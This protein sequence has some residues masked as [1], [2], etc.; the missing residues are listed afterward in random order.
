MECT[1]LP[2]AGYLPFRNRIYERSVKDRIP[3]VGSIEITSMCNLNC[4]HCYISG[5]YHPAAELTAAEI[6]GIVDQ[7][8]EEQCLW[9][10]LTGG[11]PL[12]RKDFKE[13]Y[14][15]VKRRGIIPMLFT[16]ATLVTDEIADLLASEPPYL[17]EISLYGAT[18]E[19]YERVTK[20]RG[21]FEKCMLG[22][23]KLLDRG[24]KIYLKTMV[25][26]LNSHE[27]EDMK[28]LARKLGVPFRFDTLINYR[29]DGS[30]RPANLRLSPEETVELDRQDPERMQNWKEL[31]LKFPAGGKADNLIYQCGAGISSFH[32]DSTGKL[33]V[34][35]MSR[36][37]TYDLRSGN[38][39]EGWTLFIPEVLAREWSR[40]VPCRE[41]SLKSMC[42]QC[43]GWGYM[44]NG[45]PEEKV[46]YLCA[47][48]NARAEM[49]GFS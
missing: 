5:S 14:R 49:L 42:G 1:G 43:P 45:D 18:A 33:S 21:S 9:L 6:K 7:L 32:I 24:I 22:I 47:V 34:C 17:V 13:I 31:A 44:E 16:N 3:L 2:D 11:E 8:A 23:S 20:V 15:Y 25:M 12:A 30:S 38:F 37:E 10:L 40:A 35:M 27:I 36:E 19:T 48:A 41:C 39:H 29:L 28:E 4:V 26:K 46:E